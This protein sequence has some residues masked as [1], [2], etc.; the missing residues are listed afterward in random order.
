M[1]PNKLTENDEIRVIA[2]SRSLAI[3]SQATHDI[4]NKRWQSLGL[5]ISF[6]KHC[7]VI[8][9]FSSSSIE[10][11]VKDLHDAFLDKNVKAIFTVIGGYNVN[12]LLNNIDYSIIKSTL[13]LFVVTLI[14]PRY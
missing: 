1:R 13:K 4:A 9:E 7:E 10:Q 3:I 6:S 14:S 2:P 5:T 12:Q 11:R 8:D